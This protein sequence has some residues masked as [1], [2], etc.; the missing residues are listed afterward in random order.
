MFTGTGLTR[1]GAIV[2][3]C[4]LSGATAGARQGGE[5]ED[6]TVQV[7][8]V[9]GVPD[10]VVKNST[11]GR[12]TVRG[13]DGAEVRVRTVREGSGARDLDVRI[14]Q[15]GNRITVEVRS[16]DRRW[17]SWGRS[18]RVHI[19]IEAPRR[20]DIT[21]RNDDGRLTVSGFD[22]RL[23][24]AVDDGDLRVADTSGELTVRADDG[25]L[26]LRNVDEVIDVRTDD[27]DVRAL[28]ISGELTVVG[29]DGHLDLGQVH[30]SVD[31]K[32]DDGD[33]RLDGTLTFV[34]ATADDGDLRIRVD[35]GSRM[36]EDWSIHTDD[37]SISVALPEEFAADLIL[38]TDDGGIKVDQ[39]I[40]MKGAMSRHQLSGQLNG[41]GRE[42]RVTSDDGRILISR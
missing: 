37:G 7:F 42:L 38:R 10:I 3:L 9:T 15:D 40:T 22:G 25:E 5:S 6:T 32:I 1:V 23:S 17:F 29:D 28:E 24:L 8:V 26:D 31:V 27:G 35:A 20:S 39:P 16:M 33:L 30:G 41:G 12:T 18:P 36:Q 34:R 21:A 14:H 11:D 19:E 2:A 4:V 13:Y